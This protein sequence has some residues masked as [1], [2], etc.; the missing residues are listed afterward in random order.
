MFD[1][2]DDS[3]SIQSRTSSA[4]LGT[5]TRLLNA[6]LGTTPRLLKAD[7]DDLTA[8]G[9]A[10]YVAPPTICKVV[11]PQAIH[12]L[13]LALC[14]SLPR[15]T[16]VLQSADIFLAVHFASSDERDDWV[17]TNKAFKFTLGVELTANVQK[18]GEMR[19][20]SWSIS[21]GFLDTAED[22][23]QAIIRQFASRRPTLASGLNFG[24]RVTICGIVVKV[25]RSLYK[26]KE[27]RTRPKESTDQVVQQGST[28]T[29]ANDSNA[30]DSGSDSCSP[31]DVEMDETDDSQGGEKRGRGK[32]DSPSEAP[33]AKKKHH[34]TGK[35]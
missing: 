29:I 1:K 33:A 28:T 3:A 24:P 31:S 2:L 10:A 17:N 32:E 35:A 18:F 14:R 23:G 26:P 11:R 25:L 13:K 6:K 15:T 12:A 5:T 20:R 9:S 16:R 21:A 7:K 34:S 8:C 19:Q 30:E 27:F 22:I 4:K